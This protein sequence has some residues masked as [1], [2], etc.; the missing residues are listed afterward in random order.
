MLF[1]LS[2][3]YNLITNS[4]FY[5]YEKEP[6]KAALFFSF[7]IAVSKLSSTQYKLIAKNNNESKK[8]KEKKK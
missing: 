7:E 2:E 1:I 8:G 4:F 6:A 5:N 3:F